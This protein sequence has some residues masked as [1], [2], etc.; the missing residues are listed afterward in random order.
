MDDAYV[1][2]V[3]VLVYLFRELE[4]AEHVLGKPHVHLPWVVVRKDGKVMETFMDSFRLRL[5]GY[6]AIE[7][8]NEWAKHFL[9]FKKT[10]FQ[11]K[12]ISFQLNFDVIFY[13]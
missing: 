7:C 10:L 4:K 1:Y 9:C 6:S 2:L 12:I 13:H 8:I 3:H 11:V 5:A